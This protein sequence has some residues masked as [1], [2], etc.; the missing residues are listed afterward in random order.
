MLYIPWYTLQINT[1]KIYLKHGTECTWCVKKNLMWKQSYIAQTVS[2][3]VTCR[4]NC[5][6]ICASG[7][8][9]RHTAL[10]CKAQL[11][12][13]ALLIAMWV[14]GFFTHLCV[15]VIEQPIITHPETKQFH[16]KWK[17]ATVEHFGLL[18]AECFHCNTM[19]IQNAETQN[20]TCS[21]FSHN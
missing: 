16:F 3:E 10:L 4:I 18:F 9:I 19:N 20:I 7:S 17:S 2:V 15:V 12:W 5:Q 21:E 1:W 8:V 6:T 11:M 14:W 13:V